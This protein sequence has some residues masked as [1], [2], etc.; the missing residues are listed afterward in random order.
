MKMENQKKS[1]HSVGPTFQLGPWHCWPS[2]KMKMA[3][4]ACAARCAHR[5]VTVRV[6]PDDSSVD[7]RRRGSRWSTGGEGWG[8]WAIRHR[9][10]GCW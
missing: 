7:E 10:G 3:R 6:A 2:P 4:P 8:H 1:P 5:V 9:R